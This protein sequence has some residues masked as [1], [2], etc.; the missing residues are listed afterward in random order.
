MQT[1]TFINDTNVILERKFSHLNLS[2]L[3]MESSQVIK[4]KQNGD[5][6]MYSIAYVQKGYMVND[7]VNA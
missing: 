6:P 1:T 2:K 7:L 5:V 4:D 3:S